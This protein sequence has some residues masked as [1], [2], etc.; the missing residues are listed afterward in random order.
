MGTIGWLL[1]IWIVGG[2]GSVLIYV[3]AYLTVRCWR[4]HKKGDKFEDNVVINANEDGEL[5]QAIFEYRRDN[6]DADYPAFL[7]YC[8]ALIIFCW[9]YFLKMWVRA[10]EPRIQWLYEER[11]KVLEAKGV[12]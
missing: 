7:M 8:P 9:P 1:L 3:L 2:Y 4:L 10:A 12:P 5:E 11:L 6:L